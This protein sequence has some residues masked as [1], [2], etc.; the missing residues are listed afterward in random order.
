MSIFIDSAN[1]EDIRH[2]AQWG[3]VKGVTTNP[4][5]L[6][7]SSQPVHVLLKAM[8]DS[9]NGPVFYQLVSPT[10]E[11][12]LEEAHEAE[13]L[14]EKKLVIK[15]PP[16]DLG[17]RV[18]SELSSRMICCPTAI[19]APAQALL[20]RESG[21][22][23]LAVYVNR[24]TRLLGDGL[25]LVRD[26]R[27]V[28]DDSPTRLLAASLKSPKEAVAALMAGAQDLTLPADVLRVMAHHDLS[29]QAQDQF[30]AEGCGLDI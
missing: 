14:L 22:Q 24:A 12:M 17:F 26:I 5:L 1:I 7:S 8:G 10:F 16:S 20:A 13:T 6:A 27:E 30:N 2:A 21:A 25:K 15:L 23:Y 18:C 28:L 4:L 19:Y 29:K 11:G 9:Q 3:W